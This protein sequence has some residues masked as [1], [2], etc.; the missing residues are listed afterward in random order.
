MGSAPVDGRIR[1]VL[2]GG[3]PRPRRA[4]WPG[5]K[6]EDDGGVVRGPGN[7][8]AAFRWADR[9]IEQRDQQVLGLESTPMF[10]NLRSDPRY[11]ALL[12]RMNLA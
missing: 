3:R 11:P 9:A 7:L 1:L 6:A 2:W 4:P 5:S 10:E 12:R 8:D